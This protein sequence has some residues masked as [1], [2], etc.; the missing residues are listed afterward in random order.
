MM[1]M[2]RLPEETYQGLAVRA[3]PGLHHAAFELLA[4]HING[5]MRVLD[6]A[7]GSGAFLARLRDAGVQTLEAV[8]LDT[9]G[10]LLPGVA[11]QQVDLNDDFSAKLEPGRSLI[12]ALEIIEH[13]DEPHHF[14]CQARR[15]LRDDGLLLLSTPNIQHWVGRLQFLCR[16]RFRYFKP[17]DY[18]HQRHISPISDLSLAIMLDEAGFEIVA[19]RSAGSFWG[20]LKC[21]LAWPGSLMARLL[22]GRR[23]LGDSNV[24]LARRTG[25]IRHGPSSRERR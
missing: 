22:W 16:G 17:S 24:Y 23:A 4:P 7:A 25:R 2:W 20:P 1:A 19:R 9:E 13:L 15:L 8:E 18:T 21:I 5:E 3:A 6:L 11:V 14:I 12:I 10:F